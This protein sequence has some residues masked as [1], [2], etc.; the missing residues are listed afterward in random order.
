MYR[1]LEVISEEKYDSG[2]AKFY[3]KYISLFI[4]K[5]RWV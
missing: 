4:I 1:L 3:R 2:I 5:S